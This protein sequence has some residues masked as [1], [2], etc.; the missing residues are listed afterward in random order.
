MTMCGKAMNR[1]HPFI[2]SL[3][4]LNQTAIKVPI[5]T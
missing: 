2:F 1:Y 3:T 4:R 5:H